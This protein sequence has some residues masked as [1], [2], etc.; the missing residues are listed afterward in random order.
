[1]SDEQHM[2][3]KNARR[4]YGIGSLRLGELQ[5][6]AADQ[7]RDWLDVAANEGVVDYNAFC[8]ST[9]DGNGTP[10]GRMLLVRSIEN[11][12]LHFFTNYRSEKGNDLAKNAACGATFFW[13]QL[14]R[15]VRVRGEATKL[16]PAE[17]DAYF[18]SRQR[19]SQIGAWAS[20]QSQLLDHKDLDLEMESLRVKFQGMAVIPRPLHWGGY[21]MSIQQ[22]EFWQGRPSRLHH[23]VRYTAFKDGYVTES[24]Q[25]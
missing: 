22:A 10:H 9:V 14:E 20:D 12:A 24:L 25:P 19:E 7:L 16:D 17:N 8:L 2:G 18:A 13:P 21:R 15:Q 3:L 6:C 1:M 4:D 5:A 23:R 11:K